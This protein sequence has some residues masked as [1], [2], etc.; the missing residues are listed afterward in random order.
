MHRIKPLILFAALPATPL[1]A[2][3][4]F[5]A[6]DPAQEIALLTQD[7]AKC[8]NPENPDYAG[9]WCKGFR[10]G[11]T[12]INLTSPCGFLINGQTHSFASEQSAEVPRDLGPGD[13][14]FEQP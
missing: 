13:I 5:G 9:E 3:D 6:P 2:Q 14:L 1:W 11:A 10:T 4:P 8:S 12:F 7:D